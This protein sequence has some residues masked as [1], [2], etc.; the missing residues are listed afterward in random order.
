MIY[1]EK[2]KF[3]HY[4]E[5]EF[6]PLR[7]DILRT[8]GLLDGTID[9]PITEEQRP[10]LERHLA[11]QMSAHVTL[12]LRDAYLQVV[13]RANGWTNPW[14]EPSFN[15]FEG[16]TDQMLIDFLENHRLTQQTKRKA[17][18]DRTVE[19]RRAAKAASKWHRP[20]NIAHRYQIIGDKLHEVR[21]QKRL[22]GEIVREVNPHPVRST[23]IHYKGTRTSIAGHIAMM[24]TG[25]PAPKG[26]KPKGKRYRAQVRQGSRVLHLGMYDTQHERDA[27]VLEYR[28]G[29]GSVRPPNLRG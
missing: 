10:G 9:I 23:S 18:H 29:L 1:I 3:K 2:F 25:L 11:L 17:K 16:V 15:G 22:D 27:A 6:K 5:D 14:E 21:E 26:P 7:A 13:T 24:T 12:Q 19:A 4:I 20:K 28:L 8:M